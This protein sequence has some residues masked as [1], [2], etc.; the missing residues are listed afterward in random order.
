MI[1]SK[2]ETRV[3]LVVSVLAIA[4]VGACAS[5]T[6]GSRDL[7]TT[8]QRAPADACPDSAVSRESGVATEPKLLNARTVNRL[9]ED[10]YPDSLQQKGVGGRVLVLVAVGKD[11]TVQNVRLGGNPGVR[12]LNEAALR[13]A[14]R[15]RFR[16]ACSNHG[17][18]AA[19]V[20][21]PLDFQVHG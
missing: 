7:A 9:M 2:S 19:I 14:R 11:G 18:V 15:M 21:I 10:A 3:L 17:P 13:I 4:S 20:P 8:A 16:P 6:G 12:P 1:P 5:S